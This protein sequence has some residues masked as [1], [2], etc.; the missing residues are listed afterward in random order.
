MSPLPYQGEE[1]SVE[2]ARAFR[3]SHQARLPGRRGQPTAGA[4]A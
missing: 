4:P 3:E 2:E 1:V